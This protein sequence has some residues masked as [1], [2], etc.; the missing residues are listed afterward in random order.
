MNRNEQK[1]NLE[2]YIPLLF[3]FNRPVRLAVPIVHIP[4]GVQLNNHEIF[5]GEENYTL[6]V[7]FNV[8]ANAQRKLHKQLKKDIEQ[9]TIYNIDLSGR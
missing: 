1:Q 3:W 5:G 7:S 2:A 6:L 9:K 8:V 4:V